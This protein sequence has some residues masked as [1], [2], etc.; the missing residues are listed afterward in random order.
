MDPRFWKGKR[1]LVTGHTGFKGAWLSLWLGKSGAVVGGYALAPST[2]PSLFA[3]AGLAKRVD[4]CLGDIRDLPRL[5]RA[6][7]RFR[8]QVVFHMA[9]QPLVLESYRDP[10]G[11][12]GVNVLGTVNLL[13]ACR[14]AKGLRAIVNVT[15]DKVYANAESGRAYRETDR[16]GGFDPYS[17]SKACSELVTA[18]YVDSFFPP[19]AHRSHG[20]AV[21]TARSGNVIG[22]GDWARDRLVPD[23]IRAFLA[24]RR[25]LIRRPKAIRP[26]QHV[27]EPL[28]GYLRLAERLW[29]GGAKFVG[30]WNFGP[31]A[32]RVHSVAEVADVLARVWGDGAPGWVS[33]GGRYP[34]EA[35]DLRLSPSKA[36]ARLGFRQVLGFEQ[37]L[38]LVVDW[39][40][41]RALGRNVV[42]MSLE[43]IS[44]F[45]RLEAASR[46]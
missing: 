7:R 8:P 29:A 34:H 41:G 39:Y 42:T 38:R 37:G 21:A 12:Y 20:V 31:P 16:L 4:S 33:D 44:F 30:A 22:G 26:W 2:R 1:V 13:E 28:H 18:A 15:T 46:P 6:I 35:R 3:E 14:D 25:P 17:T 40:R 36:A 27:L 32:R 45:E 11:T 24:G 5:K 10:V 23:I 43:Q 9:A 19:G